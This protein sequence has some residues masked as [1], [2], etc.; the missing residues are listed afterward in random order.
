MTRTEAMA[1][2]KYPKKPLRIKM[3]EIEQRVE[4]IIR[5]FE[6]V[7]FIRKTKKFFHCHVNTEN[8]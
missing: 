6:Q 2:G 4:A 5:G 7:N 1:F 3:Y 8:L